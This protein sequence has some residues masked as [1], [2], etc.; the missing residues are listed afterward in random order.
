MKL[1]IYKQI[2]DSVRFFKFTICLT[3]KINVFFNNLQKKRNNYL[4][5]YFNRHILA[6]SFKYL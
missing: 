1:N 6:I 2:K 5:I 3:K 4:L